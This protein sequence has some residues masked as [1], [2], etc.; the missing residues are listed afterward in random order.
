MCCALKSTSEGK[1]ERRR[2]C[3]CKKELANDQSHTVCVAAME[4]NCVCVSGCIQSTYS[5]KKHFLNRSK[6][7]KKGI[8]IPEF[9]Q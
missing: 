9:L 8:N 1:G 6:Q 7:N 3:R 5:V 2:V 4:V